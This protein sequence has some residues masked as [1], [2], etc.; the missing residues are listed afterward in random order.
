[1]TQHTPGPWQLGEFDETGG[2]DCMTG[3][4]AVTRDGRELAEVDQT[5]YGQANCD[6]DYRS[7]EAEANARLIAAAPELLEALQFVPMS[8]LDNLTR[9]KIDAAIAKATGG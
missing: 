7:D 9:A 3:S 2:Y 1:M 6:W 5:H 4:Y 8:E